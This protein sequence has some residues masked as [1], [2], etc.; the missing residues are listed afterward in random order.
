MK[1]LFNILM[2][3]HF[4]YYIFSMYYFSRFITYLLRTSA[5]EIK[6]QQKLR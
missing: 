6:K 4:K 3:S 1:F 5:V 2:S